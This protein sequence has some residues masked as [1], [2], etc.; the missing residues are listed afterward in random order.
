[1]RRR[2]CGAPACRWLLGRAARPVR[3][4]SRDR[5][6]LAGVTGVLLSVLVLRAIVALLPPDLPR[7]GEIGVDARVVLFSIGVSMLSGLVFGLLPALRVTRTGHRLLVG[8]GARG[9]LADAHEGPAH[10]HAC[11]CPARARR[12]AAQD[13]R[14]PEYG[15]ERLPWF[16]VVGVVEDVRFQG[17][18]TEAPPMVYV[19]F[20]QHWDVSSLRVIVRATGDPESVAPMLRSAVAS[21]D[22]LTPVSD[23]RTFET[24]LGETIARPRF[25]AYLLGAFAAVAIF[26]AA[27][28]VYGVLAYVMSRRIPEIGV[29]LALGAADRDVF[30]LLFRQGV[31]LTSIGIAV[32]LPLSVAAAR[33]LSGL[34]FGVDAVSVEIFGGVAFSLTLVG[35]AA[36]FLPAYR[37]ARLDPM[38]ALRQE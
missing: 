19:P 14:Q 36:S 13:Q 34:L 38:L 16:T 15:G 35:L 31:A 20:E 27:I 22:P 24:R 9:M 37:A 33:L 2:A 4:I 17:V 26:L 5:D 18:A 12:S 8:V 25:T 1:M 21:L 7:V 11:R 29:R 32:G 28:G 30:G 3:V 6:T 10:A 23:V